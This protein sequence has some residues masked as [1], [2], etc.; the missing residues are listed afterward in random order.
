MVKPFFLDVR[1]GQLT[2]AGYA[3]KLL[4]AMLVLFSSLVLGQTSRGT[5]SGTI[6]DTSGAVIAGAT[7]VLTHIEMGVRRSASANEAGLYRFDAVDLG[8]YELKV[9]HPGFRPST[10]KLIRVNANRISTIDAR[11]EVGATETSIHVSAEAVEL[12]IKDA[13]LRGGNF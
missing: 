5:V 10:R 3:M 2:V 6:T 1:D 8:T 12:V 9:V 11:L 4:W 13:P 7:L